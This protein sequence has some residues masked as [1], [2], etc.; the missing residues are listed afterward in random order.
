MKKAAIVFA[1]MIWALT[2]PSAWAGS[3]DIEI[4][5]GYTQQFFHDLSEQIGLAVSYFPLAPA[6]PLGITGF[7][8]GVEASF[9]DIDD[10]EP[11]WQLA[12]PGQDPPSLIPLPKI[13]AQKGL[14]FGIDVGAIYATVPSSNVSLL[15]GEVKWAFLRGNLVLPALAVRGSYTTLLGVDDFNL[16]TYGVDLSISKGFGFVTPY[17]GVGQV[18]IKSSAD[19]PLV[20]LSDEEI[21]V[22][23][24][25][26]GVKISFFLVNFVAE[27][28]FSTIPVYSA[29]LNVGF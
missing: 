17:L 24:G 7:D 21:N 25:F 2:A 4:P 10:N 14:P 18:W 6:E 23:K 9:A 3:N 29:R 27:A 13:H 20:N 28:S 16:Q 5:L 15:G 26:G 11:F 1:G 19:V 8:I 12:V 22:T